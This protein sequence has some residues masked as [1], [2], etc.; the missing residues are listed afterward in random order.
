MSK[1]NLLLKLKSLGL[2][3]N[4]LLG[5]LEEVLSDGNNVLDLGDALDSLLDGE[6]VGVTSSVEDVLDI[7]NVALSPFLVSGS[8]SLGDDI[9]QDTKDGDNAGLGIDNV[10]AVGDGVNTGGGEG[11]EE[12]G[13]G[14]KAVTRE[15]GEDGRG[16]S[17]GVSLGRVETT[18][19][20]TGNKNG[21]KEAALQFQ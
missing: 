7:L 18:K 3:L 11:G 2:K 21:V 15:S 8:N 4:S 9:E 14:N 12:T 16:L 6:S 5:G 1:G 13:L 17:L 19:G 10:E 20:D